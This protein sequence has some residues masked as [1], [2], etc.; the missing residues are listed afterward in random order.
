MLI[1]DILEKLALLCHIDN[2]AVKSYDLALKKIEAKDVCTTIETFRGDHATHVDNLSRIISALGGT[3]SIEAADKG[4]FTD[5]MASVAISSSDDA[6]KTLSYIE[7]ITNKAYEQIID[8]DFPPDILSI[9][10]Q[11]YRD[12]RVHSHFITIALASRSSERRHV[13]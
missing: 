3:F 10:S 7:A 9:L 4:T 1:G 6:L 11:N 12:E 5:A 2:D 13:A 8:Q